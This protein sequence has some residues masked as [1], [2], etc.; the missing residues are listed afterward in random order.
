MSDARLSP[1]AGSLPVTLS[2]P[3]GGFFAFVGVE[4]AEMPPLTT[5]AL[6]VGLAAAMLRVALR[7]LS[8]PPPRDLSLVTVLVPVSASGSGRWCAAKRCWRGSWPGWRRSRRGWRQSMAG[9]SAWRADQKSRRPNN[10]A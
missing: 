8:V 6:R 4:V 9:M 3:R 7:V 5:V 10:S 1:L 2:V